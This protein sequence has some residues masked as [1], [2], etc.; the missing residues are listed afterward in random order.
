MPKLITAM[1]CAVFVAICSADDI[2]AAISSLPE[3][4]GEAREPVATDWLVVPTRRETRVYRQRGSREIVLTNGLLSRT[5]RVRPNGATVA[6]DNLMSGQSMLRGVKPEAIVEIDGERYNVGG[7]AGQPDYAYLPQEWVD[8]LEADPA[9]FRLV[10]IEV[11]QTKPRFAW[12]RVRYASKRPWPPPG[13]ALTLHYSPPAGSKLDAKLRVSIHYEMYDGIPLISKWF[14]L[15]NGSDRD[16]RL[17]KFVSEILAV[18]EHESVVEWKSRWETPNI[19]V[20]SDYAMHGMDPGSSNRST[21]WLPDP[22]YS[23]QVNYRRQTPAML[24][25]RPPI[26]PDAMIEPGGTFESFRTFLLAHDSTERERRGLAMRR[27]YR[28][29]APWVTENPIMMHV[30]RSE[31]AAVRLAID[32]AAEVGFEMVIL[33]FGSGFNIENEDAAYIARITGLVDY[34][35]SKGV[36][37]GGY[38]LLASR[39]IDDENDAINPETGK[40]GGMI[41]GNSPC[42]G[43]KWGADYFRKLRNF[44][45]K[46]GLDLLEHDGSYPGDVCASTVH[47][48]HRGKDDSQ[49]AQWK[50]VTDFYK[51]CRARGVYLNVPDFY[52]LSGSNKTA[53]G[54][55]ET[56][57]SLPRAQQIIHGRQNIYDGTWQKT[58]SMGWMFVPLV[59]YHGGGAAATLEPLSEH[60]ADYEGHLANNFAAG[61]QACYRGPRLYDTAETEAVVKK[62]VGFYR[63]YREI[64]DSDIIHLRRA[65]GRDIDALLHV[66]PGLGHRGLLVVYNPLDREVSKT[67]KVPLYYTG[68]TDKALIREREGRPREYQLD[69]RFN[70]QLPVSI[71]PNSVTWFV[72]TSSDP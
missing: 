34:A 55:R 63:K 44:I 15:H 19:H 42:L 61:V 43:S 60:L 23:T 52:F 13:A 41:F 7:L 68:L 72:I 70:V 56:N 25:S 49:W 20:E 17:N 24:E 21:H 37:L 64:L 45:E 3:L 47:P 16:V 36:E 32:Q 40:P 35:H 67:I 58:P 10:G 71:A 46:T 4:S 66:N 28:T 62:W 1:L 8:R 54:Y 50:T 2:D 22:Q 51:W 12:K 57:W 38:S 48:G 53:M 6:L 29:I 31:P 65:D 26:G 14:T 27:M 30:R 39:R 59:E 5:W 33:T 9:A 11:G 69:R 18:V